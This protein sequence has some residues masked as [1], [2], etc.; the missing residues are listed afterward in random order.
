[1]SKPA[2]FISEGGSSNRPPLFQG[3]D[4]Y[5]WKDKMELFLRSQDNNMW[6]VVETREYTPLVKDSTTPK[7]QAEWTTTKADR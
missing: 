2:K 7:T 4:Y 1:M 5:Y 6:P 3:D